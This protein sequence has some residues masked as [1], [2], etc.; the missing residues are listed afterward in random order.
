M[1]GISKCYF[2]W[3]INAFFQVDCISNEWPDSKLSIRDWSTWDRWAAA[4]WRDG[5]SH[6]V[7]PWWTPWKYAQSTLSAKDSTS[8]RHKRCWM[9][10]KWIHATPDA[11][12]LYPWD[13]QP[14]SPT[15]NPNAFK[16]SALDSDF[17]L[18]YRTTMPQSIRV[19]FHSNAYEWTTPIQFLNYQSLASLLRSQ[20]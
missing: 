1:I 2:E 11:M 7:R 3:Q 5:V 8:I 15:S 6:P 13:R 19:W 10:S 17:N 4:A 20:M 9:S 16:V 12:S 18:Q 14:V